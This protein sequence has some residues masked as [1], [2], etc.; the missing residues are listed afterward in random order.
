MDLIKVNS[1]LWARYF[2]EKNLGNKRAGRSPPEVTKK[3]QILNSKTIVSEKMGILQ[4]KSIITGLLV[5]SS[6]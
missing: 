2:A 6:L 3:Y 4:C 5:S 1:R